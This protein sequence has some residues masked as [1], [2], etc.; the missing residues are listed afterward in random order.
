M[1]LVARPGP[2]A[3]VSGARP[4]GGPYGNG[5]Y[6]NIDCELNQKIVAAIAEL[7]NRMREVPDGGDGQAAIEWKSFD[8]DRDAA[9]TACEGGD[10]RSA[11][12]LY[13]RAIADAMRQLAATAPAPPDSGIL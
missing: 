3:S 9:K 11:V 5:P 10:Y 8:E 7:C 6:R 12:R 13:C 1:A 4:I 2:A